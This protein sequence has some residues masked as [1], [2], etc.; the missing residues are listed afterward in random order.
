M[1]YTAPP[2]PCDRPPV[3][4][5]PASLRQVLPEYVLPGPALRTE[6]HRT[7]PIPGSAVARLQIRLPLKLQTAW[8]EL[9]SQS[10]WRNALRP[11]AANTISAEQKL[12]PGSLLLPQS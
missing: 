5:G 4:A 1:P 9:G 10:L 8:G 6:S 12:V 7:G 2:V 3:A 11:C